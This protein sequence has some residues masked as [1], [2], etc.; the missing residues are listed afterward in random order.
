MQANLPDS[1]NAVV[2]NAS[3]RVVS[4][5]DW[6]IRGNFAQIRSKIYAGR[7]DEPRFAVATP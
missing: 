3:D 4:P 5:A 7:R 2:T 1:L 6:R